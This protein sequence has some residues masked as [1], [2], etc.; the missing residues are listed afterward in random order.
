MDYKLLRD[1]RDPFSV[2]WQQQLMLSFKEPKLN[3]TPI[4]K[5]FG[6]LAWDLSGTK[7]VTGA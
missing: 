7:L 2:L 3:D 1:V 6:A 4:K 5:S